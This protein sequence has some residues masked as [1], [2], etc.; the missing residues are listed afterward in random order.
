M[1]LRSS[2]TISSREKK[3]GY[4][5]TTLV[6]LLETAHPAAIGSGSHSQYLLR[7][8][9]GLAG[10]V[11]F[12]TS[13]PPLP[14]EFSPLSRYNTFPSARIGA[15]MKVDFWGIAQGV[16]AFGVKTV[17]SATDVKQTLC[18]NATVRLGCCFLPLAGIVSI[19]RNHTS[20]VHPRMI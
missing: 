12:C 11:V 1:A 7:G 6:R 2:S 20:I 8:G 4:G 16:K 10:G 15:L 13:M 18:R 5:G 19:L 3:I 17:S 9:L 14:D